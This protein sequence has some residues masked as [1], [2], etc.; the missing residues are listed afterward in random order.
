MTRFP[1]GSGLVI[2]AAVCCL[3]LGARLE[4]AETPRRLMGY[5][6]MSDGARLPYVVYLPEG[7][8]R[9]P[10]LFTYNPYAGGGAGP[11]VANE[12]RG[13][14]YAVMS[15][16]MRGTGCSAGL[17][18]FQSPTIAQDGA[19]LVEWAA[20]QPWSD[21]NVGMFG[22]SYPGMTQIMVAGAR[23]P[24]L[25]ALAVGASVSTL[26]DDIFYPGGIFNYGQAA[27]W[28]WLIQPRSAELGAALRIREGDMECAA[29]RAQQTPQNMFDELAKHPL[30]DAWWQERSVVRDAA[31]LEAPVLLF[32]AWQDQ[33]IAVSASLELFH[34]IRAPKRM[35]LS[36]GSHSFYSQGP[37]QAGLR[38]RWFER[39]LKGT[40]NG[41]EDEP[42]VTVLFE[43]RKQAE[44]WKP[45]WTWDF[46]TWPAPESGW[47][48]LSMTVAGKLRPGSELLSTETGERFYVASLG[49][50]L[51]G[52][53]A[54]FSSRPSPVGA[55][56]YRGEPLAED[57]TV[58][59]AP[60][61]VLQLSS[62]LADTDVMLA[63][64]DISPLGEVLFVQRGFLRASHQEARPAPAWGGRPRPTHAALTALSQGE[65]RELK[66]ALYPVGHVFRRGHVIELLV[67]SPSG[68]PSPNWAFASPVIPGR[69]QVHHGTL[70]RSRLLL[71]V[72]PKR[73]AEAPAPPCGSLE[74]QPCFSPPR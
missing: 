55:L 71:P 25:R 53:S 47:L 7:E 28:T 70:R 58:L 49:T 48:D 74:L 45:G 64:H 31:R 22:N 39:W 61:V 57:T 68:V 38:K 15:A 51:I 33:Q 2:G 17:H 54:S 16:S 18:E 8:G 14:G 9:F 73:Q 36:N 19:A 35:V 10:V 43:N 41:V 32:H 52:D 20:A 5:V 60:E 24:H 30:R 66:I 11:A 42:A 62:E 67:L 23:P 27:I 34:E 3:A 72:L 21:G 4:A 13:Q 40:R 50:E 63:L 37:V 29:L 1:R 44:A 69:N 6:A 46:S 12:F 65:V 26:Y 59:G 56:S